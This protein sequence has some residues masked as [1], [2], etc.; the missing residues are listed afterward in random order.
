MD[1]QAI[2]GQ[3]GGIDAIASQ[4]GV[5]ANVAQSGVAALL[6]AVLGGFKRSAQDQPAGVEGLLGMIGGLGGGGLFE[7]VVGTQPTAVDSG[8]AL[9]GEMFGSK[10]GSIAVAQHASA[11]SG[12]DTS[13][14][15]KML[16]M[17]AM[18]VAGA[19]AKQAGGAVAGG[20]GGGLGSLLGGL[21]GGGG[22]GGILG[23]KPGNAG[24][25]PAAGGI[26]GLGSMLDLNGDGNPLDDILGMARKFT[27]R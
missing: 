3:G 19:M 18:L 17:V 23:G 14:L 26:G 1:I 27:G 9:L 5:P 2:I 8:N 22:L 10:E 21:L 16:P 15:K 6:P 11:A 25:A 20:A 7:N 24:Q 13:I 4:L 12:I